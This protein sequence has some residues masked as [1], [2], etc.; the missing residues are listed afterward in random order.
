MQTYTEL[1]DK[2]KINADRLAYIDFMLLFTG[3]ITRA[4]ICEQF[5]L[6][7]PAA[8]KVLSAYNKK[9]P[10][11]MDYSHSMRTNVIT[12]NYTPLLS[13]DSEVALGM[14]ANG[15]NK[16]KLISSKTISPYEKI[17]ELP[18]H[19]PIETVST[20]TRAIN[21]KE[22]FQ[23]HYFSKNSNKDHERTLVPLTLIN[24]GENWMFRAY[25]RSEKEPKRSKF[26][27]FH[28]ARVL[29]L[30]SSDINNGEK[31]KKHEALD[32]DRDWTT[33]VPLSL[34]IHDSL[35]QSKREEIRVDFGMKKIDDE[36]V[37][38][39]RA[40]FLWI[41]KHKWFIDT[42]DTEEAQTDSCEFFYKFKL[43][44]KK[45]LKMMLNEN[46]CFTSI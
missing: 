4:D 34:K 33:Q 7:L 20:I 22:A 6:S 8:T 11:N 39:K 32:H 27:F 5:N 15:F 40:A 25:D 3:S 14:L 46:D 18:N 24:D 23:C 13:W 19:V 41:L 26:K 12:S 29:E 30:C 44:N 37:V 31:R 1:R 16:N 38:F 35:S 28:F 10:D 45:M 21:R 17:T 9:C 2:D 43:T 42:R 36:L